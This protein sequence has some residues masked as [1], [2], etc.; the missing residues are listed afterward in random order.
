[1]SVFEY[2][3]APFLY[4]I[5]QVFLLGYGITNN[6][7]L[8][9]V[10][11]SLIISILLLPVFILIEKAKKKDDVIKRAM[12]PFVD[13]I[14]RCYKGQERHYYLK[15][16]N[17]Q[18]NYNPVRSL[19]PTLSLVLQ[20]PFFIAAYQF[21][22]AYE[23][24][25]G[26]PFL[27]IHDLNL[28]DAL[29]GSVNVL[30]IAMTVVNLI[31]AYFYTRNGNLSELK[32][33]VV[34][35]LIF[36]VLLFNLPA[37]LV[38]YWTLNN[39]FSFFRLFVTNPEAFEKKKHERKPVVKSFLLELKTRLVPLFPALKYL[40]LLTVAIGAVIV[41]NG[42]FNI[43][44][45]NVI[46]D[47]LSVGMY[48][49]L[50]PSLIAL[51]VVSHKLHIQIKGLKGKALFMALWPT[52]KP[53][54]FVLLLASVGSQL[55][56]AYL[57]GYHS[58]VQRL[59]VAFIGSGVIT[60][61]LS[62]II[63]SFQGLLPLSLSRL[64]FKYSSLEKGYK[65][66]LKA[67]IGVLSS[68]VIAWAIF[69][70][71]GNDFFL[72]LVLSIVLSW[73]IVIVQINK[74]LL[75]PKHI[76]QSLGNELIGVFSRGEFS[77]SILFLGLYFLLSAL[78]YY[79]GFN[80]SLG[81]LSVLLI[82]IGQVKAFYYCKVVEGRRS[83]IKDRILAVFILIFVF[84]LLLLVLPERV[85]LESLNWNTET[86]ILLAFLS[87]VIFILVSLFDLFKL[88]LTRQIKM[89]KEYLSL[90]FLGLFYVLG[91]VFFW[92]PIIVYASFPETFSFPP[93]SIFV[94]NLPFFAVSFFVLSVIYLIVPKVFKRF[95]LVVVI[96]FVV[97]F[98]FNS[99]IVPIKVGT[100]QL[101]KYM[102]A[103]EL[104]K[105]V[106]LYILEGVL[107][108]I[109]Y[110]SISKWLKRYVNQIRLAIIGITVVLIFQSLST[111]VRKSNFFSKDDA[112]LEIPNT[113]SFSKNQQNI[114]YILA[115]AFLGIHIDSILN[116]NT[117]LVDAYDGFVWYPNTISVS[118][119]T[120]PSISSLLGGE[121]YNLNILN[122]DETRTM[123]EKIT[124]VS[125]SF[126]EKIK[127]EGY[128]F[129]STR[130]VYSKI[131]KK[132]Y[133]AYLP[134]WHSDWD[135]WNETL[136]IGGAKELDFAI[137][138]KNA[139]F[140]GAPLFIKPRIYRDGAWIKI[141]AETNKNTTASKEGNFIRL[142]PLISDTN[143][144][145][146]NFVYIHTGATHPPFRI[147]ND[148]GELFNNV[149]SYDNNKWF[150][151]QMAKWINW[152]K[153]NEVYANT[154]IIIVSDHGH[155]LPDSL[156]STYGGKY[157]WKGAHKLSAKDFWSVNALLMVK[158]F[159]A[160]QDFSVDWRLMSN[161]DAYAIAFNDDDPRLK[162]PS[163]R[164]LPVF[165]VGNLPRSTTK[166][167]LN[168]YLQFHVKDSL[169]NPENWV[170]MK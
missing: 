119:N 17:R 165:F 131:D 87:G 33:M 10:F 8:S 133:D 35:A 129:T 73:V 85:L 3:L 76:L 151:E 117:E 121:K 34:V 43:G 81:Y 164:T 66:Q 93:A 7:G 55:S 23:P 47:I 75:F 21:L 2:V 98:F 6:Y 104:I 124:S 136:S 111:S 99:F 70:D 88:S 155:A 72:K 20:I 94:K 106:T 79:S 142:L 113:I 112:L 149:N 114:V 69:T 110:F 89:K 36:L 140:Y 46:N 80:S 56:W 118:T 32:Q 28:P 62:V 57:N 108:L 169:Y 161:S 14:K 26:V 102:K 45:E 90:Y 163:S 160:T 40:F 22:E 150:I 130:M 92:S 64:Q 134:E 38:L 77:F 63:L 30:P 95:I 19:I 42:L 67:L 13:E 152:L 29:L 60:I 143:S 116:N 84:Q 31:T 61:V 24:L 65:I 74:H 135:Q 53:M 157:S 122:K 96:S 83:W 58:L 91:L 132:K 37:G 18:Y 16:L 138:W 105:P 12:K 126:T 44:A 123:S 166:T 127:S 145:K 97:V 141:E 148:K 27:F 25:V 115:D 167:Q 71:D 59:F 82:L 15:T 109:L 86:G 5:E 159:N 128:T 48:S 9:I 168:P 100:L 147:V 49:L 78:F 139:A 54:F 162:E 41:L 158:D 144:Q 4:L 101:G 120:A 68:L 125:E 154:K 103:S 170:P 137:L 107:L 156:L 146:G 50:I 11:L 39:V 1:M 52:Y 51:L 153:D